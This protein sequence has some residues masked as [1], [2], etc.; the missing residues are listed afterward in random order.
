MEGD[1]EPLDYGNWE[2]MA[3][4]PIRYRPDSQVPREMTRSDMN[5]VRDQHV[6][7]PGWGMMPDS[8]CSSST[9]PMAICCP[10]SSPRW[11]T[12]AATNTGAL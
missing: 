3:P 2:I 10:A 12:S 1:S 5:L 8:I 11:P 7:P 4:S 6:L 9:T